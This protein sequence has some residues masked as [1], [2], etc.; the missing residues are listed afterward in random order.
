MT[1]EELDQLLSNID[2]SI[3]KNE[4]APSI[5]ETSIENR[6]K[7]KKIKRPK[8]RP[9]PIIESSQNETVVS[10]LE[11]LENLDTEK[12]STYE[13]DR[14]A[15]PAESN[16]AIVTSSVAQDLVNNDNQYNL[17]SLPPDLDYFEG[18]VNEGVYI[19]TA[20]YTKKSFAYMA[21]VLCLFI[22]LY[23]GKALFSS[24][25]VENYVA[26]VKK[27]L[28]GKVISVSTRSLYVNVIK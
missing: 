2:K 6:P 23:V 18:V 20:N 9:Q 26:D 27:D 15:D 21:A 4:E 22:G 24:E 10:S 16:T 17:D 25:T 5:Q 3:E 1:E 11:Q 12:I 19:D 14:L 8:I 28:D 13:G 7:L